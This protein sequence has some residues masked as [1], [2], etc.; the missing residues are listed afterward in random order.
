MINQQLIDQLL[1]NLL[2]AG[3]QVSK[4]VLST[5]YCTPWCINLPS[6]WRVLSALGGSGETLK[7]IKISGNL[8]YPKNHQINDARPSKVSKMKSKQGP[9]I[10]VKKVKSN[11]NNAIHYTF[12]RLGHHKSADFPLK[13]R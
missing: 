3:L 9:E 7:F 10:K 11:E 12:D 4:L 6:T 5:V 2:F 8:Q 1:N 13:N